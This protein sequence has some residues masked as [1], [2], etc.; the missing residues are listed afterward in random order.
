MATN[1]EMTMDDWLPPW[2]I[3]RAREPFTVGA[4]LP[5]RDGRRT[6]NAVIVSIRGTPE[7]RVVEVVTDAGNMM[8]LSTAEVGEL[9]HQPE[10]VMDLTTHGGYQRFL[11]TLGPDDMAARRARLATALGDLG[12]VDEAP[13]P[14]TR[15][16]PLRTP[17]LV[18]LASAARELVHNAVY[19]EEGDQ[20]RAEFDA[21]VARSVTLL[22][23]INGLGLKPAPVSAHAEPW[24]TSGKLPHLVS[25]AN[26]DA[27]AEFD[28]SVDSLPRERDVTNARRAVA[29]V[30]ACAGIPT[31][32]LERIVAGLRTA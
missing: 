20:T 6:G 10:F 3:A 7:L 18:R 17:L 1:A 30:N 13:A 15:A 23:E 21:M 27:V 26:G 29:C 22:R 31:D 24:A 9:F 5:T 32:A 4:S 25:D 2:A 16:A 12:K 19:D 28:G 11:A 8:V 14:S